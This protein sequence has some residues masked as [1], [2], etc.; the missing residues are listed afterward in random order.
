M[1]CASR[2]PLRALIRC[3]LFSLTQCASRPDFLSAA[4]VDTL[5]A[6]VQA[7]QSGNS[8]A[9]IQRNK[10]GLQDPVGINNQLLPSASQRLLSRVQ[11]L[12]FCLRALSPSL[13]ASFASVVLHQTPP[14]LFLLQSTLFGLMLTHVPLAV[15]TQCLHSSPRCGP[16]SARQTSHS[17]TD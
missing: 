12:G 10:S 8:A 16:V 13:V 14:P 6:Y 1:L 5:V 7:R 2:S 4:E 9:V 3:T 17:D 11:P 15:P